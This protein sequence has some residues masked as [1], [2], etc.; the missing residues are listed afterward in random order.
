[1]REVT[2]DEVRALADAFDLAV[3]REEAEQLS[4]LINP[5][6]AV[7]E[8]VEDMPLRT[9]RSPDVVREWWRPDVGSDN[10]V[11]TECHVPPPPDASDLLDGVSVGIKDTIPVAGIPM[12][13]GSDVMRGYVPSTDAT[14]VRRLRSTGAT[15]RAKTN[16]DEFGSGGQGTNGYRGPIPNPYDPERTAGGSSGGSAVAVATDQVDLGIGSD[17]GGSV[18]IPAAYCGIVGLKPTYGLVPT[19]GAVENT[20]ALDHVGPM[21]MSVAGV[22]RAL[23]AVAGKEAGDPASM[24]AAGRDGYDA[25]GYLDAV[26]RGSPGRDVRVGVL[27]HGFEG[28]TSPEVADRVRSVLDRVVDAGATAQP[29]SIEGHEYTRAV[30]NTLTFVDHAA[31]WRDSGA[32]YRRGG[33]VD[34]AYQTAFARR[35]S[36]GGRDLN[37]HLKARILTGAALVD[38]YRGR[39]Y[40]RALA[41]V[42]VFQRELKRALSSVDVLV[43]PTTPK[44]APKLENTPPAYDYAQNAR[45]LNLTGH[46]A[47]TLPAGTVDGLPVGLQLVGDAF[48]ESRLLGVAALVEDIGPD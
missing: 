11:V 8:V 37:P 4:Q 16:L 29:V 3:G 39:R 5:R 47:V 18:R 45:L 46:P 34:G 9:E 48:D 33:L 14:V 41:C 43:T 28:E 17:T 15:I 32:P 30:K 36:G 31:H 7:L 26:E 20:Y 1:M 25:G 22:A 24:Q 19:R 35:T 6:L 10:S 2:P 13:C 38:R 21:A 40:T 44:S 23:E 12:T 42:E 27:E